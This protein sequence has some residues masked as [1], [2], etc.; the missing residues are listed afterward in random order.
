MSV[1]RGQGNWASGG[2]LPRC[3]EGT[4]SHLCTHLCGSPR[5]RSRHW[6]LYNPSAHVQSPHSVS[7]LARGVS[8]DLLHGEP[9]LTGPRMAPARISFCLHSFP[10]R[11]QHIDE[12]CFKPD[13]PSCR[14]L[15]PQPRNVYQIQ[16]DSRV[17]RGSSIDSAPLGVQGVC[18][19]VC[20]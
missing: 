14:V 15:G 19:R 5:E 11:T 4:R 6:R 9:G 8:P 1:T 7:A 10:E 18:V 3:G 13:F 16:P 20:V 2:Q 12:A 17:G